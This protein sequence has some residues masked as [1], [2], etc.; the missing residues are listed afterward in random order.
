L[1]AFEELH[2]I[3]PQLL[4]DG[5]LA[6]AVHGGE[7]TVAVVEIEPNAEL[8]EHSHANEQFGIVLRGSVVFR[9][10]EEQRVLEPGALWKIGS[11][12][13]HRVTGGLNGAVVIDVFSPPREDWTGV[14]RLPRRKPAWP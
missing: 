5:Y 2:E 10:G 1:S 7:L 11:Q 8:P 3:E 13:P 4:A 9:V 14:E 12:T 6:R